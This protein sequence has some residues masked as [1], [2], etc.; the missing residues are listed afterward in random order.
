MHI[1][2]S[3]DAA[4]PADLHLRPFWTAVAERS[5]NTAFGRTEFAE[6]TMILRAC[7][8]RR[9]TPLPA[10]VQDVVGFRLVI[11]AVHFLKAR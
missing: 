6:L 5:G 9:G 10:A 11:A 8:K 2:N 4:Q 1:V 3:A 7:E